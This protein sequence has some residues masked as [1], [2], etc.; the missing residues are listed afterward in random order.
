MIEMII[1]MAVFTIVMGMV[2][3]QISGLQKVARAETAKL[4]NT[5]ESREFLD[6]LVRD[7][8]QAGFPNSQ[9]FA[10]G[11]L[12]SPPEQDARAAVG[13]VS[14]SATDLWFEGDLDG[15]G[16]VDS[17]RYTLASDPANP[18]SCPCALQRSQTTKTTGV[19]PMNQSVAY[20]TALGGVVNSAGSGGPGPDG[21]LSIAGTSHFTGKSGNSFVANDVVYAAAKS[22]QV[23]TAFDQDGNA[24]ALPL[25]VS[26]NPETIK[27]IRTVRITLNVLG[28]SA[29]L[30][31]GMR[32]AV[33]VNA[34]ARLSN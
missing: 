5:Q 10:P 3:S 19:A 9:M 31:D 24:V 23:F 29:E 34:A 28:K 20:L 22:P 18:G 32:P 15:D 8:H 12:N 1:V 33:S 16:Q 30:Q 27:T 14:I 7:L 25:T 21:S 6:Q 4:D 17:V 26:A 2:F 13:L 11:V